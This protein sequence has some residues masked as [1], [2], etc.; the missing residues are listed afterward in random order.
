MKYDMRW[1]LLNPNV[2]FNNDSRRRM[3]RSGHNI[4]QDSWFSCICDWNCIKQ[5]E[6]ASPLRLCWITTDGTDSETGIIIYIRSQWEIHRVAE[7][8]S[9]V[10]SDPVQRPNAH[11]FHLIFSVPQGIRYI[12]CSLI[13][14]HLQYIH[15]DSNMDHRKLSVQPF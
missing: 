4:W 1:V 12:E 7:I 9:N 6:Y 2:N 15:I 5:T 10:Q 13:C 11:N 14:I 3:N 8:Q